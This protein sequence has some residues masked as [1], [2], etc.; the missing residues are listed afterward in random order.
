MTKP[1]KPETPKKKP[2]N[3]VKKHIYIFFIFFSIISIKKK[4]KSTA[5]DNPLKH[6]R[7]SRTILNK[8]KVQ[9][10]AYSTKVRAPKKVRKKYGITPTKSATCRKPYFCTLKKHFIIHMRT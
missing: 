3:V 2:K 1:D 6:R 10:S 5:R 4:Y 8:K 9:K 7:K